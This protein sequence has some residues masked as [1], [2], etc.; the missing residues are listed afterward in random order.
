MHTLYDFVTH[1]KI[2]EYL[3]AISCIA[4]YMLYWEALKPKPFKSVATIAKEDLDHIRE[5]GGTLK[6]VG[7]IAAAPFIGL[8]YVAILPFGFL[9]ALG[10]AAV[11]GLAPEATFGW[12]PVRAYLAGRKKRKEAKKAEGQT[13]ME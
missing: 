8:A 2:V 1:I 7:K 12:S 13:S 10:S 5:T 9:F 4:L 11:H 6:T 3:I